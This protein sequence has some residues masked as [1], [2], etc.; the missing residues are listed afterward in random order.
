M[1]REAS[2]AEGASLSVVDVDVDPV[3]RERFTDHVPVLFV[4]GR[5]VDY[6]RV[7]RDRLD[8]ALRG[9]VVEPPAPL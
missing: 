5:L 7:D 2:T 1:V 8:R 9:E 4:H 6:W 3:V